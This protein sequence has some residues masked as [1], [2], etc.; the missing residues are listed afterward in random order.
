MLKTLVTQFSQSER[1]WLACIESFV[2]R[3]C[4]KGLSAMKFTEK[5]DILN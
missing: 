4:T 2:Q 5:R 1:S 3:R